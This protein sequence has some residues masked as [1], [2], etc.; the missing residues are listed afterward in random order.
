MPKQIISCGVRELHLIPYKTF[1]TLAT[2]CLKELL[3]EQKCSV[4]YLYFV[5]GAEDEIG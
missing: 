2:A 4:V 5:V 1:K 3:K